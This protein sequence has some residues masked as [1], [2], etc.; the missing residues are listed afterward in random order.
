MNIVQSAILSLLLLFSGTKLF[1]QAPSIDHRCGADL[2]ITPT[3]EFVRGFMG[4][5]PEATI[6]RLLNPSSP[7]KIEAG[8]C[9][10]RYVIPVVFHVF[11]DGGA[12]L[13]PLEQIESALA[14][15]NDDF[16]G[17]NADFNDLDP[18]FDPIK[19]TLDVSF[20]LPTLDPEGN[21]TSGI[22]Y[23]PTNR[24]FGNRDRNREIASYAWDNY[25]Y[26]N[27]YVM[28]DLYDNQV[29]NNSGIAWVPDTWMSDEGL[30]RVVY[31]YRYLG[32]NG[33]SIASENFQSVFTHEFGH[34]L[35]LKHTFDGRCE[36]ENDFVDDTP[37]TERSA[38]CDPGTTSCG[39]PVNG[40][41]YMDYS[42]CY[43]MFTAGQVERMKEA[44]MNHPA[45]NTLW[46]REN[47]EATGTL[48]Y[49]ENRAPEARFTLSDTVVR[50][51]DVVFFSDESCGS[52]TTLNWS[53]ERG[54]PAS[55]SDAQTFSAFPKAGEYT[56]SLVSENGS[57]TSEPCARLITV[58]PAE[59]QCLRLI[60]FEEDPLDMALQGWED[61]AQDTNDRWRVARFVSHPWNEVGNFTSTPYRS[62]GSLISPGNWVGDA[63]QELLLTSPAIDLTKVTNPRLSYRDLRGWDHL[64]PEEKPEHV[65]EVLGSE[66]REGPWE[67]LAL[68]TAH[69]NGFQKWRE[70]A[71]VDLSRFEG[72]KMHLGFRTNTHHYYWRI[73]ALCL[74]GEGEI[75]S[76]SNEQRQ[77]A[78]V[79]IVPNPS[80]GVFSIS[81]TLDHFSS[82][83]LIDALGRQV[84]VADAVETSFDFSA[85]PN[86]SY[87]VVL[88]T[89][90]GV[91]Y[92]RM[93]VIN[94]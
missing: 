61:N 32:D 27:V 52:P 67:V 87:T 65:V 92:I 45:R 21:P 16:R 76:A 78:D 14:H 41:N 57:G 51:G 90:K 85:F 6:D 71:N 73:D 37:S 82:M 23:Y 1:A 36:G 62:L 58:L 50:E 31:N 35:N 28:I 7:A 86:G 74:S 13:V 59:D 40:E 15:V 47:L 84:F 17:L 34:W 43:S 10:D 2:A 66:S 38:G 46:T 33:S 63:P 39:H 64:W 26:M 91:S 53:F 88:S 3:E 24:G 93:I 69:R 68:D 48:Q 89:Q 9:S 12:D 29:H 8:D 83:R 72:K 55:S 44:L 20:V 54:N 19:A 30:A 94:R 56:V 4:Y 42:D 60:S 81:G 49:L 11:A 70:V 79:R 18:L 80:T 22:L 75:S 25:R 77:S 5:L